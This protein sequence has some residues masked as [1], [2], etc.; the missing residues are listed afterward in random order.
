M[1][2]ISQASATFVA[3]IA[4]F[5]TTKIISISN[6][7]KRIKN[8]LA[9]F[10]IELGTRQGIIRD[11]ENANSKIYQ[12]WAR[13]SV[14]S[15][16]NSLLQE[17]ILEEYTLDKLKA[18]FTE[19][20]FYSP[21]EYESEEIENRYGEIMKAVR[22]EIKKRT[23][24]FTSGYGTLNSISARVPIIQ[25]SHDADLKKVN[26]NKEKLQ[27]EMNQITLLERMKH[28][29]NEELNSISYPLYGL[30]YLTQIIFI[31]T[32]VIIP[33]NYVGACHS[34]LSYRS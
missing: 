12:K 32:G 8:K 6:D 19:L 15:F 16:T 14:S 11:Y 27:D 10:D 22:E 31:I 18:K 24:N 9:E 20:E 2:T 33:L 25:H 5:F 13:E 28:Q 23:N 34:F 29:Y 4:G 3:I 7:K 1:L 21:D 17:P 30:G 26:Y